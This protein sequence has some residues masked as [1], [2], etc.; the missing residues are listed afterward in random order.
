[1]EMLR[2]FSFLIA[3]ALALAACDSG[4]PG[5]LSLDAYEGPE[6]EA[7]VRHLIKTLPPISP[8]IP[9]VYAIVKG[10]HLNSTSMIFARRFADLKLTFVSAENLSVRD[11][12]KTVVDPRSD[13]S[14]VILQIADIESAGTDKWTVVAGWAWKKSYERRR[15]TLTKT[16][17]GDEMKDVERLEGN[18]VKPE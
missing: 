12:D 10:V 5:K 11:P 7:V 16:A 4:D 17:A 9:K 6:G 13:T 3:S 14:P 1:M 18:Y 2:H 8:E 15:Y